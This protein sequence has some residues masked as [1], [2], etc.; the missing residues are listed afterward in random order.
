LKTANSNDQEVALSTG[1]WQNQDRPNQDRPH[2]RRGSKPDSK[3]PAKAARPFLLNQAWQN[4][5]KKGA[6]E[7]GNRALNFPLNF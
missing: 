7:R 4:Q 2:E 1:R 5:D 6:I 3:L